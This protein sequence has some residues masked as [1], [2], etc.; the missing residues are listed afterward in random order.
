[1]ASR[2]VQGFR[3]FVIFV[4]G[5]AC[6]GAVV[7]WLVGWDD[8]LAAR[9]NPETEDA[10]ADGEYTP[11]AAREEGYLKRLD[12]DDNQPVRAGQVVAELEDDDFKAAV[13]QAEGQL[14]AAEAAL[15]QLQDQQRVLLLQVQQAGAQA[16]G[17][18]AE[19][20]RAAE[21]AS[22]QAALLPTALGLRRQYDDAVAENRRLA[23]ESRADDATT[24]ER[25]RQLEVLAA[26]QARAAA[27]IEREQARLDLARIRLGYATLRA[28]ADG[29]VGARQVRVGTLLEP[30]TVVVPM[31]PLNRV[32]V[33]AD[34]TERQLTGIRPGLPAY[35][36]LDAY[37]DVQLH[38]HV[39]GI[40]PL[41]GGQLAATPADNSTGNYTKVVQ[42]V[43]VKIVLDADNPL[44][45]QIRPGMSALAR[46][47]TSGDPGV[48]IVR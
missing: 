33:V 40:S 36:R 3:V 6:I 29:V 1:M 48:R 17:T 44:A 41:T 22:R 10:Y 9:S 14:Q 12:V 19:Q 45:G 13:A 5:A 24:Q 16:Q 42:R 8:P 20:V 25:R 35:V 27:D 32:W 18:R 26:Q 4:F 15:R 47:N 21:E 7:L 37:P 39:A 43:P 34:F 30:G 38:G 23:A 31:I 46:V 28:P 11:L 2:A